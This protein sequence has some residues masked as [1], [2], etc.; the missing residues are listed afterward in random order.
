MKLFK[1]VAIQSRYD[2]SLGG[3]DVAIE[4]K[5]GWFILPL[6]F[7]AGGGG[8]NRMSLMLME[9][10]FFRRAESIFAFTSFNSEGWRTMGGASVFGWS[11]VGSYQKRDF[12]ERSYAD[13]GV[14]AASASRASSDEKD[15]ERLGVIDNSYSKRIEGWSLGSSYRPVNRLRTGLSFESERVGYANGLSIVPGDSGAQ[16]RLT[17]D[18]AFG[19]D[20]RGRG[21]GSSEIFGALFG[22]G[23]AD[24]DERIRSI[25]LVHRW[26]GDVAVSQGV[27]FLG[28]DFEFTRA[29]SGL[30]YSLE[31]PG[32]HRLSAGVHAAH[33]DALPLSQSVATGRMLGMKGNYSR[34]FRGKTGAGSSVSFAY[35]FRKSRR[36]VFAGEVFAESG[37]VW[38]GSNQRTQ[39]GAGW[40][41]YYRFW[42]FP[43]PLGLSYTYSFKDRDPQVS[44]A[45]GGSFQ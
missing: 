25:P 10:N 24:V 16:N 9:R 29:V 1:S 32:R 37:T 22:L 14:N 4:A 43:L 42:R 7:Y 39:A 31:F 21:E 45:I 33:G 26:G 13:G 44:F 6:P 15:P 2:A 30:S 11:W 20:A 12:I 8:G 41:L 19:Q 36:G 5:D 27:K 23:L 28:S 34:E 40:S 18:L 3:V 17:A 35:M 38:E